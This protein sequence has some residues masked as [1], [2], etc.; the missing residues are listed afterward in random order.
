M[1]FDAADLAKRL[2]SR[3]V[4][5]ERLLKL[6]RHLARDPWSRPPVIDSVKVTA[7]LDAI[8][9][10]PNGGDEARA[11]VHHSL[12]NQPPREL[13]PLPADIAEKV[14]AFQKK[15]AERKAQR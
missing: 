5:P 13:P 14:T 1:P 12:V 11:F 6:R 2:L 9:Q 7:L 4:S 3:D 15:Q 10:H 8:V